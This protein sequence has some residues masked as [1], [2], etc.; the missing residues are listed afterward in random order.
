M[1]RLLPDW[2]KATMTVVRSR[3]LSA[4]ACQRASGTP[5]ASA[6]TETFVRIS[7]G[8]GGIVAL[9]FRCAFGFMFSGHRL[10]YVQLGTGQR[11][12][13]LHAGGWRHTEVVQR[14]VQLV[15][16]RDLQARG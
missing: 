12:A 8:L 10:G 11:H 16:G 7:L 15:L 1:P 4:A 5:I 13:Q 9:R 2:R 6:K 3:S 14:T